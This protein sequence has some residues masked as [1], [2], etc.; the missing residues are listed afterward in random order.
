MSLPQPLGCMTRRPVPNAINGVPGKV[1]WHMARLLPGH[2]ATAAVLAAFG[3][4]ALALATWGG[5]LLTVD[6]LIVEAPMLVLILG[7][8]LLVG[9]ALTVFMGFRGEEGPAPAV[10]A[11]VAFMSKQAQPEYDAAA[12][13][14]LPPRA[15][16][17][18]A[19]STAPAE[20]IRLDEEIQEVSR[21]INKAGVMLAT[22]KLSRE[23]YMTYV[24]ELK[25][26]RGDLEAAR[27]ELEM[28]RHSA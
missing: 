17:P 22:G 26:K 19:P 12:R 11:H 7:G 28:R 24:D 20:M 14:K 21:E 1:G 2:A 16:R 10:P 3:V 5:H 18:S 4:G 9:A 8:L 6:L 27:I 23:G 15:V 25:K 13:A